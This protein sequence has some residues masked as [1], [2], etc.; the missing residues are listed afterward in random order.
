MRSSIIPPFLDSFLG[1]VLHPGTVYSTCWYWHGSCLKSILIRMKVLAPL[2]LCGSLLTKKNKKCAWGIRLYLCRIY[3]L[4]CSF[5]CLIICFKK[6]HCRLLLSTKQVCEGKLKWMLN[7]DTDSL[8][9][10]FI[11]GLFCTAQWET[12]IVLHQ[13]EWFSLENINNTNCGGS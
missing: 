11:T 4:I 5:V 8:M 3:L 9:F 6:R 13:Q 12:T 7:Q 2:C 1:D 10:G